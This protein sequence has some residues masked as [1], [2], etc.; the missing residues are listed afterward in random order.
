MEGSSLP[1]MNE[2]TKTSWPG[3]KVVESGPVAAMRPIAEV[4]ITRGVGKGYFRVPS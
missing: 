4:P 2:S 1:R 3:C